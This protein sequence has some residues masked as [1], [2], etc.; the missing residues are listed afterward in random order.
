MLLRSDPDAVSGNAFG[1]GY[2]DEG[3]HPA[4]IRLE[5]L[6]CG[7]RRVGIVD[8]AARN[9]DD[10]ALVASE[11][12]W[13]LWAVCEGLARDQDAVDPGLELARDREI[14]HRRANHDDVGGQELI[15]HRLPRSDILAHRR[16]GRRA[17]EGRQIGAAEMAERRRAEITISNIE[18]GIGLAQ[19]LDNGGGHL[20]GD[21]SGASPSVYVP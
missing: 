21:R 6:T 2:A 7:G 13:A 12:L 5:M 4:Q 18:A 10:D 11:A 14:V 15:K 9:R 17:R 20:A 19:S 8:P 3:E 1:I 16:L